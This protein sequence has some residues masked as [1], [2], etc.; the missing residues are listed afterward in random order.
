M[1]ISIISA[2]PDLYQPFI[3]TS[4]VGRAQES[5]II[6]ISL[7]SFFSFVA[8]KERIDAP[9]FGPTAGMIIRPEVVQRAVEK[10]EH[11]RGRAL[12]I[13]FSP[14]GKKLD[15][16]QLKQLAERA[17]NQGHLM[18]V[19]GRYEGM[20]AR[21][22]QEYADEV[23]SIGDFVVMGGDVPA[24]LLL[25]GLLRLIPGV[26][27]RTESV[28]QDSFSGA[29][30]DYPEY[31]APVEW[32]GHLVPEIVRSGNHGAIE[33]WRTQEAA[34]RTVL[35]HFD[36]LRTYPLNEQEKE[37]AKKYMPAHYAVLMHT[38]VLIG[39]EKKEGTTSVTSIDI[40]DI[41]RSSKMYSI[42]N[43]F[44][45]T[46]LKDQQTIVQTLLDFWCQGDGIEYNKS[47]HAAVKQV[48]LQ[49]SLQ[50]VIAAIEAQ[51]GQKPLLIATSAK[52]A[53]N[54][55]KLTYHDQETVWT[56]KRPVLFIFGTGQGLCP[57][58][59]NQCDYVL[60]PLVG[61]ADFNHLSVR[62]AVAIVLDR[63]LGINPKRT[64]L[65]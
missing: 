14:H 26:I 27:G 51:E 4:L 52:A 18:L 45:V 2:F 3:K 50:E 32:K 57:R 8:P 60:L 5:S 59:V 12:R 42:K 15:Q 30:V 25:E 10:A 56:Q 63:W 41:A 7:D 44:L 22:E 31:T 49:S 46:P 54:Q 20:D 21:V 62:S 58:L 38:D 35:H 48:R 37:L 55:H 33:Q 19:A 53:E 64:A 65:H 17:Y 6:T 16:Q 34:Q 43:F 9:T 11:E 29:F 28:E 13:F 39:P 1:N 47:R 23:I 40:H 61:F 36:W 24:M